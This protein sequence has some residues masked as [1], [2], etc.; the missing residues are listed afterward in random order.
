[1]VRRASDARV[2][3]CVNASALG[4]WLQ[5]TAAAATGAVVA[6]VREKVSMFAADDSDD[7]ATGGATAY[8]NVDADAVDDGETSEASTRT[9]AVRLARAQVRV[10]VC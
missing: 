5:R 2:V 3:V 4:V 6:E 7:D 9:N 1:M 8:A 10:L